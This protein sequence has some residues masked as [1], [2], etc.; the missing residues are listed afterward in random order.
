MKHTGNMTKLLALVLSLLMMLTMIPLSVSADTST[1]ATAITSAADFAAMTEDG[2]Y[3]L[4]NDIYITEPYAKTFKGT[5]DG[6]ENTISTTATLFKTVDGATIE[7][8]TISGS[9]RGRATVTSYIVGNTT[10]SN[11]TNTASVNGSKDKNL[12][13]DMVGD[14]SE[15]VT[16]N[17][18]TVGGIA[19]SII[20]SSAEGTKVSFVNCK[21]TAAIT[22]SDSTGDTN[23]GG[24]LGGALFNKIWGNA[25]EAKKVD[26]EFIDCTNSGV[27]TSVTNGGGIL[28]QA[29]DAKSIT[30]VNC[31]NTGKITY[32]KADKKSALG[33]C[34]GYANIP[35]YLTLCYNTAEIVGTDLSAGIIGRPRGGG[36]IQYCWNTAP[37]S[38]IPT[39]LSGYGEYGGGILAYDNNSELDILY[40]YNTGDITSNK[41]VGGIAGRMNNILSDVVGCYSSGAIA[42]NEG[43]T[44]GKLG[45]IFQG[46]NYGKLLN[47][48]YDQAKSD[49]GVRAYYLKGLDID[50]TDAIPYETADVASGKLAY[51]MNKAIGAQVYYQNLTDTDAAKYPTLNVDDGA[52]IKSGE[53]YYSV[54][55]ETDGK[56]A[57]RIDGAKTGLRITTNVNKADYDKLITAGISANDLTFGTVFAPDSYVTAAVEGGGVFSMASLD[58][59]ITNVETAYVDVPVVKKGTEGFYATDADAY[60]FRGSLVNIAKDNL[61]DS[62]SAIGYIKL[63][64]DIIYS[65]YYV[66]VSIA[67]I[68]EMAYEDRADVA[69]TTYTQTIAASSEVAIGAVV[70]YSPYTEAQLKTLKGYYN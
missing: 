49:A 6:R 5:L 48:Y 69:D 14:Y 61:G 43:C 37:V 1:E 45:Q 9:I 40:C 36:I 67:E 53:N 29:W 47:N 46:G 68:A 38:T 33:G 57:V 3:Y 23:V 16:S 12:N 24:I 42:L 28:G 13:F 25:G 55:I 65:G 18:T 27:I 35:A 50:N 2:N 60:H 30:L 11:V 64:E 26:V 58:E 4:A 66:T 20:G 62:F 54:R 44:D 22:V 51:D 32:G 39:T 63:G 15:S 7:N 21:N 31:S 8:L 56:A 10:F 19:G 52:V 17:N 70:T 59:I 34:V 41:Y